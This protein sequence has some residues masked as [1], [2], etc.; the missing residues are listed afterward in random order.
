MMGMGMI[1]RRFSIRLVACSLLGACQLL[2]ACATAADPF[3]EPRDSEPAERGSPMPAAEAAA[4]ISLPPGFT[5]TL[6]AAEPAVQNPIALAWDARGRLWVAEN[7]TYAERAQR[8]D[9]SLRDRVLILEDT[10]GDGTLDRRKVFTDTVQ[11]LTGIEVGHGGVWLICPPRLLFIPDR[12]R[13][14]QPDGPAETILDGFDVAQA[15]YH[16]FANGLKFGPDGWLYGRC[17]HSCPA[18]IGRAG[19]PDDQRLPMTG[20]I[21][22]YA[23]K[24]GRVEVVS[25]GATNP[26]GHDW[27]AEGE[28]FFINTV[29]GHLWHIIPG[30]HFRQIHGGDPNP[31]SYETIDHHADHYHFDTGAGWQK[32]RDG[33]ASDLGG[34]HAHSGCM[35]YAGTNWPADYR[36]RLFT[37]NFHGRRMNQEILEQS[38]SGYVGRHGQDCFFWKDEW[39]RGMELASGPDGSVMVLDWSDT[40]ECHEHDGVHRRSGRI[41]RLAHE[42]PEAGRLEAGRLEAGESR[43]PPDTAAT[44]AGRGFDLHRTADADLAG[45]LRHA[46]GWWVA[47]AGLV[48]AER[49]AA[50]P[51]DRAAVERLEEQFATADA[52]AAADPRVSAAAH[53]V[54][55]LLALH[56]AGAIGEEGLLAR[57]DH[58]DEHV[59]TWA[60][61]LLTET[62]PLDAAA[63]P[64]AVEPAVAAAIAAQ[65]KTLLGRF[66]TLAETD[67]SGLVRLAL[68]ST[69]QRLPVPLRPQLA[70]ALVQR[71]EDADDHNLPLLVWY[72]LIP[73]ADV[74]PLELA[75][76]AV[77]C[78]WPTTRRLI[79]RR[80]A[81]L[82]ET[83][84]KAIDRL[85]SESVASADAERPQRIADTLAGL[86]E[87]LSGWRKAPLPRSWQSLVA[88][89]ATL[90]EGEARSRCRRLADE[91]SVVFGDGRAIAAV[92]AVALDPQ[93]AADARKT[94][95]ATLIEARAPDLR[96]VCEQLLADRKLQAEAA[97]GLAV[98]DDPAVATKLVDA[99]RNAGGA[100]REAIFSALASRPSFVTAVLDAIDAGRL[101]P[102]DLSAVVVRQIHALGDAALSERLA[103]AWGQLRESPADKQ[104]RIAELKATLAGPAG[105]GG[106]LAA[107]RLVYRQ[108]CGGC[109]RLYGEGGQIG[110]DLTGSGRHDLGYLLDNIVDPSAVVNRDWRLST[111]MLADGRV[112]SGVV[113]ERNDRVLTLQGVPERVTIPADEIDEIIA[114]DRSPMP[115]GLLDQLSEAQVRDLVA[116]L[117]HPTQVP[118][119]E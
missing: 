101:Q 112:L 45:L 50:G 53:R 61:R 72:G 59:R 69:L 68:A 118:L 70:A 114:T 103:A 116:Y 10:D 28:G 67:G 25:T 92:R 15:N 13:D 74:D 26:W 5:A 3:P 107:G 30:A 84:P 21:W 73:V 42:S 51:L 78:R 83:N 91:L 7:Y 47:R 36:G 96:E 37:L 18:R 93:V 89:V 20:G 63:G 110:P 1:D 109:H 23:P 113:V 43:L 55:A 44:Q 33:S 39:F 65:A 108:A 62:W 32:S 52:L 12:D 19:C 57:L 54:R 115:D 27:N 88:G 17:G 41:Y 98:F 24:T 81:G 2:V 79:A 66:T 22:R 48:L 31:H 4:A 38:G 90:P 95:L 97:R 80:L 64:V 46:D 111:V 82:I 71:V 99:A 49:A 8:F 34:G 11:M 58:A 75:D 9:L 76:L 40:G 16:N 86:A 105:S 94:A 29:N 60:I 14:D 117:R 85:L 100:D 106:D 102:R 77:E 87:G 56:R 119:P 35:I 104:R 6:A